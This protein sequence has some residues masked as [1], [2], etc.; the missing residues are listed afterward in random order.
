MT[1]T[2]RRES[3]S[4]ALPSPTR[5]AASLALHGLVLTAGLLSAFHPT[6]LSGF[7]RLQADPGDTVL[8]GYV[9]EHSWRW[10]TRADAGAFWSPAFFHPQPLVL[11]YSENLL[12]TA[13]LYWLARV[14]CPPVLAYQLWMMLVTAL[15]YVSFAAVLRRFG[16]GHL[17]AALGGFVFAF[18]LP[19]VTQVG[20]QQLLPHLFAPWAVLAVWRFFERPTVGWLAAGLAATYLQLLA[21]VYLGWFLLVGLGLFKGALLCRRDVWPPLVEFLRRR[22]PVVV[23]LIAVWLGLLALLAWPYH[24]ANRGFHRGYDEVLALTPRPRSWLATAP[25]GV[26][27]GW[28]PKRCREASA[29]LWI[30]PGFVPL[31]AC[32]VALA[33]SR[34]RLVAASLIA[35]LGLVFL[36]SRWGDWSLWRFV[37]RWIPSGDGIRAVGRVV[38]TVESFALV[39]GLVAVDGL[40]R[41]VRYGTVIA[42]LVLLAGVAEQ[43][44]VGELP[45]FDVAPWQARVAAVREQ[46]TP[47]MIAYVDLPPDEPFWK[48]QLIA[49]WAGMEAGV[50]VVNGYSG[51]YPKD[52]PGDGTRTMTDGELKEW[53]GGAPVVRIKQN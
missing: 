37:F 19:R 40:L 38:F 25:N 33:R 35:A 46:M 52:Y 45:A 16:V 24:E 42:G 36:A 30:F 34:Q 49:M 20:H 44:P 32:G 10:L 14:A 15:T 13:P 1:V 28:L 3:S 21:S 4:G 23:G 8:N 29:E 53:T 26:W 50:P 2:P 6:L 5:V 7:A 39:G 17:L 9:L 47:G 27:Y 18:G 11:A 41:R 12:G 48:A 51:R 31:A 22:W 43:V